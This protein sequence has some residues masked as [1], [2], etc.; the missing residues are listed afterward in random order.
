MQAKA[1][2]ARA[3]EKIKAKGRIRGSTTAPAKKARAK[4][5]TTGTTIPEALGGTNGRP[6]GVDVKPS[7]H[8]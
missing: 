1:M 5:G 4:D 8:L 2:A 7:Y 3:Q 6:G